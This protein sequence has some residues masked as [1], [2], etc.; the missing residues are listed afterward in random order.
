MFYSVLPLRAIAFQILFLLVA[1]AIEG[2]VLQRNMAIPPRQAVQY[3]TILNLLV[4]GV[5]WFVFFAAETIMPARVEYDL[6]AFILF[7]RWS[8]S[9]ALWGIVTGFLTFFGS[10]LLKVFSINKLLPIVLLNQVPQE[11]SN[12]SSQGRPRLGKRTVAVS[13][14]NFS[15]QASYVLEANALSYSAILF[16]LFVRFLVVDS[17]TTV[18]LPMLP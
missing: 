14:S 13:E 12:R 5:G 3:A 1:I 18:I 17:P 2:G 7:N 6:M 11:T 9:A 10:F 8:P 4:A 15:K 16:L